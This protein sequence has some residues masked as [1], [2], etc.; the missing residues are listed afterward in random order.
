MQW[1]II[2][3]GGLKT[4]P[5]TGTGVLTEDTSICGAI[6]RED[7]ADLVVKS[8]FSDKTTG[9]VGTQTALSWSYPGHLTPVAAR[10]GVPLVSVHLGGVH[11]A[12]SALL[13]MG[14][15]VMVGRVKPWVRVQVLSAVDKEQLF[16]NPQFEVF[17]P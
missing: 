2:R 4:D 6:N 10:A 1:T 16:G 17:S 7:V 3:P 13:Y 9:K 15:Q 5:A 8:L 14:R 11:R 12:V